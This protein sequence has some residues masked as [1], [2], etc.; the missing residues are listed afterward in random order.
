M[1]KRIAKKII[2]I[3]QRDVRNKQMAAEAEMVAMLQRL[4]DQR[5]A[6]LEAEQAAARATDE[7]AA[8]KNEQEMLAKMVKKPLPIGLKSKAKTANEPQEPKKDEST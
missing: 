6:V 3:K 5:L 2:A 4:E 7:A 8:I 1:K